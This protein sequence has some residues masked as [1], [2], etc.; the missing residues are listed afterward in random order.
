[1]PYI[2]LNNMN[3][4]KKPGRPAS[5]TLREA[6][7]QLAEELVDPSLGDTLAQG[8]SR[9]VEWQCNKGHRWTA[10]V[11]NRTNAKNKTG[12]PV[13]SGKKTL[14]GVNDVA[15][16]HPNIATLFV[17]QELAKNLTSYS[18]KRVELQCTKDASH[19][20]SAP[21]ARLTKQRSGCPYCVNKK[22]KAR[23]SI[24][25][26]FPELAAQLVDPTIADSISAGS[27]KKVEW[28]CPDV[29]EHRWFATPNNRTSNIKTRG[30]IQGCPFCTG[31]K[32]SPGINDLATINP[33]L[34]AE[35]KDGSLATQLSKHSNKKVEWVCTKHGEP[36]IWTA[37]VTNRS[38]GNGCPV[39]AGHT[40]IPGVTTF[41]VTHPDLATEVVDSNIASRVSSGSHTKTKWSCQKGHVWSAAIKD[42]VRGTQCPTCACA[43][44]SRSEKDLTAAIRNIT[45]EHIEEN[46]ELIGK[47]GK[48]GGS[49]NYDIVIPAKK[50]AIEFNGLYW[51][52]DAVNKDKNYHFNKSEIARKAGYQ[53]IHIWED[54]WEN[55]KEVILQTLAHKLNS[56]GHTNTIYARKT[57]ATTLTSRAARTFLENNHIQGYVTATRHFCLVDTAGTTRAVLSVRS[58]KNNARMNRSPG[59]WEVQRY[60]TNTVVP[61]GFSKLLKHAERTLINEGFDLNAWVS[62][63]S[64][65]I[66][67]GGMYEKCGFTAEKELAPDYKYFGAYTKNIRTPK[68]RFQKS[69]FQ[70]NPDLLWDPSWTERQCA[71]ANKL[72]RIYDSG[73]I[74][75]LK[76]I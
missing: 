69:K 16:T 42:R 76:K 30:Y 63:S 74:R 1:M 22:V 56:A 64:N 73:K 17:D 38:K 34:A 48:P 68:E 58:P 59:V 6:H 53:L 13:C 45:K 28:Q 60:A 51:H 12:C 7:P 39:C 54:D 50:V 21:V 11:N 55:K 9:S 75:W 57:K 20:W 61:G 72:Y 66:S 25:K 62:F 37:S 65:D 3:V 14:T 4:H 32:V 26:T 15:T 70:N 49:V 47:S 46:F 24:Q 67:D 23:N 40:S 33:E 27:G 19:T 29:A 44:T 10:R 5:A 2:K 36:F 18:N 31:K 43:H 52:S 71:A 41:D 35:L 8:S